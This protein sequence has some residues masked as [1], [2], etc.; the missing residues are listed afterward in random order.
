MI[1]R[2]TE[3][4]I[5]GLACLACTFAT[6]NAK[7]VYWPSEFN[8]YPEVSLARSAE[9]DNFV[10]LWGTLAGADPTTA[11]P[12]INFDP[13]DVLNQLE[14]VYT[15]YIDDL[16]YLDDSV[17][18][19]A[20]YKIIIVMNDTWSNSPWAGWAFGGS[21]D[22]AIGAMWVHP[23]AT[24]PPSWVL[25]H[26]FAHSLQSQAWIDNPGHGFINY[27]PVG[28]FWETHAQFMAEQHYPT[29]LEG[30]DFIRFFNT[31]HFHWGSTRHHYGNT[32]FLRYLQDT[33]GIELINRMWRES[34]AGSEH[35][36]ETLKRLEGWSQSQLN[37]AFGEYAMKNVAFD[38]SN[39]AEMRYTVDNELDRNLIA[40][41][42]AKLKPLAN[43]FNAY[44]IA[45]Y[46]APQDYGYN[47]VQLQ[48]DAPDATIH[49]IFYGQ[50]NAPAG[51][52]EYRFGLVALDGDVPRYSE[53]VSSVG[54]QE[55]TLQF[56]MAPNEMELFLVVL[57]A[58][59]V[60][61]DYFW[62]PGWPK[63]YR[64]PWQVRITGATPFVNNH[65]G[66]AGS[67]HGNGGG[68]VADT[69]TVGRRAYVGPDAQVLGN[70]I[71]EGYARVEDEATVT[72]FA[73][74]TDDAII[75]GAG[76]VGWATVT[77]SVI[78]EESAM[79]FGDASGTYRAGGD[80]EEHSPCSAGYY[81][82]APHPNNG[83][84]GCDG[85]TSHPANDDINPAF[86]EHVFCA[87][88]LCCVP[89]ADGDG[90]VGM[91]DFWSFEMCF[92]GPDVVASS[93]CQVFDCAGD[94]DVDVRDFARFQVAMTGQP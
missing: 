87:G 93:S 23:A 53:L 39:G 33:L 2:R 68:F 71:L 89:D 76:F 75:R 10:V 3:I 22:S 85:L 34:I 24:A 73:T 19:L 86:P 13:A 92:G 45:D 84:T 81:R 67:A 59:A 1:N 56:T 49:L 14:L 17:G 58:P 74:V 21:Y 57:G 41:R 7:T 64:Y 72:Q 83:R 15:T 50:P 52:A 51:G 6:S 79:Q 43:Q 88:G 9:S 29:I 46:M 48:A 18:N 94:G 70:A 27:E 78:I 80:A 31:A 65:V 11:P 32:L 30:T 26:E 82:Q 42:Y 25:A 63:I 8:L 20:L 91:T 5:A 54:G 28:F 60:H 66:I 55:A 62:E 38:Y 61:H 44:E 12:P 40:R 47:T 35:P 37:D 90:F 36:L 77:D 69:A 16:G 4:A